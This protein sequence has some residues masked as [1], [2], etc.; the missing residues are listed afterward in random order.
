MTKFHINP[1][2]GEVGSCSARKGKCPF[3]SPEE[4]YESF[5]SARNA[6]EA[7]NESFQ[8]PA[9]KTLS[10][11]A[12]AALAAELTP[13]DK[14]P[15]WLASGAKKQKEL[16]GTESQVIGTIPS[17]LGELAV[18]W[19]SDSVA[20]NDVY[21]EQERGYEMNRITFNDLKTGEEVGYLKMG[22]MNSKSVER[23]FG[24]DDGWQEF[25][26]A[27]DALGGSYG[28]TNYSKMP[29]SDEYLPTVRMLEGDAKLQAK[30]KIWAKSFAA[31]DTTPPNFDRSKLTWGSLVN[32]TQEDAPQDEATLDKDLNVVRK[33][34]KKKMKEQ[35]KWHTEPTVDYINVDDRLRGAG[36]GHALYIFGARMQA[37]EG[38]VL[39]ASGIQTEFAQRSWQLMKKLGLPV[40]TMQKP[41]SY[42]N[43]KTADYFTLDFRTKTS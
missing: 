33:H 16:F 24:E 3:G 42:D 34:L 28:Y 4:H 22:S 8:R 2:T 7:M 25:A 21:I 23:S 19:E 43:S 35:T 40:K 20:S 38:R 18:V 12:Q 10:T 17:P 29:N 39:R 9:P 5:E 26:W 32:L 1:A 30:R 11:A 37:K 41:D 14:P 36:M 15:R 27:E 31:I 6:Y 13:M